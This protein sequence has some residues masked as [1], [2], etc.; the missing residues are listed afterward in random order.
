M[1]DQPT[2]LRLANLI[3]HGNDSSWIEREAAAELR[4]LIAVNQELL[5]ALKEALEECIWPNERLSDVHDKA[6]AAIAK[7]EGQ[8]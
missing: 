1:A 3:D 6:R 4:R 5:E 2:A 8:A 7:A